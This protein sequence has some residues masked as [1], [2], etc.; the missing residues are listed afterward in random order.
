M[1]DG[2]KWTGPDHNGLG[3]PSTSTLLRCLARRRACLKPNAFRR[4]QL[5]NAQRFSN[6]TQYLSRAKPQRR[7]SG[8][9]AVVPP[10]SDEAP[11]LPALKLPKV[12]KVKAKHSQRPVLPTIPISNGLE[13]S[14]PSK[15]SSMQHV[16]NEFLD[17]DVQFIQQ[18]IRPQTLAD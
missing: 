11:S 9:R 7:S 13:S 15:R 8:L 2:R 3:L 4:L 16:R 1:S 12:T 14:K 10:S 6:M 17:L 5:G 18:A